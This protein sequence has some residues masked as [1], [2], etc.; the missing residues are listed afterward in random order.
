MQFRHEWKHQITPGERLLLQS[1]LGAVLPLDPHA[2]GGSYRIRSLY[3]DTPGD[4]A[5]RE[6]LDGADPREKFR[7]RYYGKDFRQVTLEKKS[8]IRGLCAKE[9]TLLTLQEV[10]S[11]LSGNLTQT[12]A[13][14]DPLLRELQF[15]ITAQ[16]LQPKT[17]VDYTRVPYVYAPGNV[18]V[19]LDYDLRAGLN[20]LDFLDPCSPTLPVDSQPV[21][22]E[23][24]WD[25]FLPDLVRDL[26]QLKGQRSCAF[27]KYAACRM[28]G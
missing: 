4:K 9:Q 21:I 15:K 10:Q 24:K 3:F 2:Q 1:R 11:I 26:V 28:Y 7:L 16:G 27:S 25:Q 8:K 13:L 17:I 20:P 12:M 18:R 5:L 14:R 23:V 22:L 6:K 19:T